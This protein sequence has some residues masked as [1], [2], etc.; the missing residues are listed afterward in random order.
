[1]YR[2]WPNDAPSHIEVCRVQLPGRENRLKERPF[3]RLGPLVE[4]LAKVLRPYLDMPFA[5]FGHSVGALMCFELARYLQ[6]QEGLSPDHLFVSGR[7]APHVPDPDSPVHQLPE[8]EFV[9]E[10]RRRYDGIPEA[11]LKDPELLHLMLPV[12]RADM[13]ISE[14]YV[15]KNGEPLECPISAFGGLQ[16]C[17][18]TQEDLTAWRLQTRDSFTLRML[19]G[20]HFFLQDTR[21]ALL[22]ALSDDLNHII[23]RN[24]QD[25]HIQST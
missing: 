23:T 21:P 15:Y 25:N 10:V 14:T 19:P 18:V 12:V 13:A 1:M 2:L 17:R 24:I 16:D 8:G 11:V 20:N 4:T 5:F 6:K 7:R 3:T 22:R 9:E